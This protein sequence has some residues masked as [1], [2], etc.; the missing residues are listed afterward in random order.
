MFEE[1]GTACVPY[2]CTISNARSSCLLLFILSGNKA[3]LKAHV[4][5]VLLPRFFA[6]ANNKSP[7]KEVNNSLYSLLGSTFDRISLTSTVISLSLSQL[8]QSVK[9]ENVDVKQ[10][11]VDSDYY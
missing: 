9:P 3:V 11:Y 7:E 8:L 5:A 4:E 10:K 1:G 6:L 2:K